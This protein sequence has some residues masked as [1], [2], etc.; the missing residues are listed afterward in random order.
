VDRFVLK[1]MADK[2]AEGAAIRRHSRSPLPDAFHLR[3]RENLDTT[4]VALRMF[5]LWERTIE[6]GTIAKLNENF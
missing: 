3:K 4:Y 1:A 6:R 5:T 2:I